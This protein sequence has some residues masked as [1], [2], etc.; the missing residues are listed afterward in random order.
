M[1]L[2]TPVRS[3]TDIHRKPDIIKQQHAHIN[4]AP[5]E[6]GA[7]VVRYHVIDYGSINQV[8]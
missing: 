3:A 7:K 5:E 6:N 4:W 1:T 8:N 2:A